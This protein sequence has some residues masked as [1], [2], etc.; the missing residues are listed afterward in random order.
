[1]HAQNLAVNACIGFLGKEE[2]TGSIP[3][4]GSIVL[5]SLQAHACILPEHL[6]NTS[7]SSPDE[8]CTFTWWVLDPA[9]IANGAFDLIRRVAVHLHQWL[10]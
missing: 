4:N 5:N 10:A 1:M 8:N 2:V 6:R 7:G 3:V 9:N